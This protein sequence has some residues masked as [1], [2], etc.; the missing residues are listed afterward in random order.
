MG[1]R[2]LG[3]TPHFSTGRRLARTFREAIRAI[4]PKA[5]ASAV[6][7]IAC[8]QLTIGT[9]GFRGGGRPVMLLN[10][11]AAKRRV[12]RSARAGNAK[13]TAFNR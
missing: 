12:D 7:S 13:A 9:A 6:H 3:R 1:S 2:L 4:P 5:P 11:L 10:P 8:F